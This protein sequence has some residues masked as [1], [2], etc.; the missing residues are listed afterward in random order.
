MMT[1]LFHNAIRTQDLAATRNF[2]TRFLG[3]LVD[4][5]RPQMD[6]PGFWLRSAIPGS[7]ALIH[8]FGGRDA[9]IGGRVPTGGGAVHHLSLYCRDYRSVRRKLDEYGLTW[10]G[11][12][13]P[14]RGL[15]QIFVHDPNGILLELTFDVAAE[16]GDIPPVPAQC[17]YDGTFDWF[18]PRQY[19]AF[20]G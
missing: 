2:Y 8:V 15:L 4:E 6:V 12:D 9:E 14:V 20:E 13:A 16:G 5:R 18:D 17:R 10:R 1:G 19:R 7:E 3:M 11:Q